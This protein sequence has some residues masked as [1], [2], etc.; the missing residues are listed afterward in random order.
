MGVGAGQAADTKDEAKKF[1]GDWYSFAVE[2]DGKQQ[3]VENKEDLHSFSGSKWTHKVKGRV[4]EEG[5]F[6]V[7][8][9]KPFWV[10]DFKY[11]SPKKAEGTHWI[12]LY[13]F[14]GNTVQWIGSNSDPVP[15]IGDA[16]YKKL[17]KAFETKK[18]DGQFMRTLKRLKN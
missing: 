3:A 1:A 7:E 2:V 17:P 10:I 8:A 16:D 15:T 11:T 13:R 9:R 6:T 14:D 12:A 4:V 5:A 18:E